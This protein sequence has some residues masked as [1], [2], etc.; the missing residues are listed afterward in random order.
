MTVLLDTHV[1]LWAFSSPDRLSSAVRML[2]EDIETDLL[3]SSV[4]A[5]EIATKYRLGKLLGA[6]RIVKG[7][8]AHLTTL[9]ARELPVGSAHALAAGLFAVE[10]RDPFDRVLA[11]QAI[12]EHIPLVTADPV[13]AVFPGLATYW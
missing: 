1:L 9:G 7:Y 13:M 12:A 8:L 4:S 6:D 5:W 11:A 10:H 3:V 2:L